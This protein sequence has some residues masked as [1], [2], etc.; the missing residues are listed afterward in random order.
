MSLG[1]VQGPGPS[2]GNPVVVLGVAEGSAQGT[3]ERASLVGVDRMGI[4][5]RKKT[6]GRCQD[7]FVL[8][9][10]EIHGITPSCCLARNVRAFKLI[11]LRVKEPNKGRCASYRAIDHDAG[12]ER[13]AV[14]CVTELE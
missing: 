1:P 3:G 8:D 9:D 11:V 5:W 10:G 4:A 6:A 7:G 13:R 12:G 14:P 2:L